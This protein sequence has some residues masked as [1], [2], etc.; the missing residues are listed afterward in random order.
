[1]FNHFGVK[2][3]LYIIE[4]QYIEVEKGIFY[5]KRRSFPL[6]TIF[7][8]GFPDMF[9]ALLRY[10]RAKII[11]K[12][13]EIKLC[14]V[15]KKYTKMKAILTENRINEKKEEKDKFVKQSKVKQS[16][17]KMSIDKQESVLFDDADREER[18][19]FVDSPNKNLP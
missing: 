9:Y 12:K 1:M 10:I 2:A 17:Y 6:E 8:D 16:T 4:N 5:Q 15:L 14:L 19:T 7:F 18:V 13:S 11:S 3:V